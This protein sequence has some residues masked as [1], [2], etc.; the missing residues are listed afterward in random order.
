VTPSERPRVWPVFVGF[1]GAF[2]G[3]QLAGAIV[4]VAWAWA[5]M[6]T[7]SANAFTARLEELAG[8]PPGLAVA[9]VI[10]AGGLGLAAVVGALLSR[11]PW[12]QRLRLTGRGVTVGRVA[13][14]VLGLLGVSQALDSLVSLLGLQGWGA[15]EHINRVIARAS[16]GWL[17][18]LTLAVALGPGVA[19]EM[20]FRG[21]MQTRLAQA[22]RPAAAIAITAACFGLM[23]FDLVHTPV[24]AALGVFMG[25]AAE[26]TGTIVPV[27]VAHVVNNMVAVLTARVSLPSAP[28]AQGAIMA[29][30]LAVAAL[31]AF[32]IARST[33]RPQAPAQTS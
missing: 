26:R 5:T 3:L 31:A 11:E 23:H 28:A 15:L 19:E 16:G 2:V 13:L 20:F 10:S 29:G 9:A 27:M 1:A 12:R 8:S 32:A 17:V 6:A 18:V 33:S 14:V 25:W 30:S 22:F 4:L 24:A 21:F 7:N